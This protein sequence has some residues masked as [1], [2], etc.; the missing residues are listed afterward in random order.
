M[1][2]FF[3]RLFDITCSLIGIIIT[4]P[5]WLIAMI[6]IKCSDP[7]PYFYLA[8]RVGKNNKE[9]RMFKFRSMRLTEGTNENYFKADTDRIFP[10]GSFLRATKMDELPQLLNILRGDMSLVGPRPASVDQV[11]IVRTGK[12]AAAASATPGLTGPSALYDYIYGDMIE[13]EEE[14]RIKVL[15]TRLEL[16]VWYVK[17][18]NAKL[19][20]KMIWWTIICISAEIFHKKT[21][22]IYKAL[23]EFVSSNETC[24]PET[25]QILIND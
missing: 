14:Y 19:D 13:A 1:Y 10:F 23:T 11:Q 24:S 25:E 17:N 15:P 21:P 16:D 20:I 7:G 12:N 22:R 8:H 9:F 2:L 5:L 18:R 3:K 6:G 4:V